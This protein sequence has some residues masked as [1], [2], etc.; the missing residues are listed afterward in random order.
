[1]VEPSLTAVF[2]GLE[3]AAVGIEKEGFGDLVPFSDALVEGSFGEEGVL[4]SSPK[5]SFFEFEDIEELELEAI[6]E[7]FPESPLV[8]APTS[9]G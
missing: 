5:D 6:E 8:P 2:G 4:V 9:A 7:E 3:D 1:M